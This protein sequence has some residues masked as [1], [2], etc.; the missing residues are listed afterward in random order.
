MYGRGT[1]GIERAFEEQLSD[2][3]TRD[4]PIT[5]EGV[6]ASYE[7]WQAG[8]DVSGKRLVWVGNQLSG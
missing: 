7:E 2:P 4:Q 8:I 5:I 1:A 6:T 3:A